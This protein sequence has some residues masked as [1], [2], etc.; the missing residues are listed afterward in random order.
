MNCPNCKTENREGAGFCKNCGFAL[1]N[2][3]VDRAFYQQP[4]DSNATIGIIAILMSLNTFIW[5]FGGYRFLEL[6]NHKV[7][8]IA[9]TIYDSGLVLFLAFNCKKEPLRIIAMVFTVVAMIFSILSQLGVLN[10]F[11][12]F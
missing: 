10:F 5:F 4:G 9:M 3:P 7:I 1:S 12:N 8:L 6:W 2:K 11:D